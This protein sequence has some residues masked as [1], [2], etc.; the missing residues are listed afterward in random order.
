MAL[1]SRISRL[2]TADLHAVLDRIE[3]PEALLKQAFREMEDD[4]RDTEH[5]LKRLTLEHEQL[6]A[7]SED[8][9]RKLSGLRDE[10]E[11]CLD[12]G[13][14]D[15]ARSLIRRKLQARRLLEHLSVK[16]RETK[17]A[18]EDLTRK[19]EED[20]ERLEALR[21]K[22]EVLTEEPC[23]GSHGDEAGWSREPA[24]GDEEIEVELLK[25]KHRREKHRRAAS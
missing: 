19:L 12:S 5:R 17:K 21:D 23:A 7:R 4:L 24:I 13:N 14:D 10:L 15:L 11:I 16:A 9:E 22:A 3:E 1:I 8:I 6:T 2:F 25:E 18:K 20:R